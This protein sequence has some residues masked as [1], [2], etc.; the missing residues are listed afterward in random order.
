M[1]MRGVR[2]PGAR[3][4]TSALLGILRDDARSRQELFALTNVAH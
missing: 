1:T 2:S 3:T 4:T